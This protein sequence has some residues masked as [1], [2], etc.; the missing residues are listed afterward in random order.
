MK[1]IAVR[2]SKGTVT[3]PHKRGGR[4][5]KEK[6]NGVIIAMKKT[7]TLTPLFVVILGTACATRLALADEYR[8]PPQSGMPPTVARGVHACDEGHIMT[9]V[10]FT[11]GSLPFLC[12]PP[13]LGG[14][15]D[16]AKRRVIDTNTT[17]TIEGTAM[18][19][20]PRGM[21]MKGWHKDRNILLC[22]TAGSEEGSVRLMSGT[23]TRPGEDLRNFTA[24]PSGTV[25]K[26]LHADRRLLACVN[27]GAFTR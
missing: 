5:F 8:D 17:Q 22:E 24:C 10:D 1:H 9:G 15:P 26:G 21:V 23:G 3:P 18:H 20:C 2:H 4:S 25:M 13:Y 7:M 19:V 6:H 16:D 11:D 14:N 12:T 27:L